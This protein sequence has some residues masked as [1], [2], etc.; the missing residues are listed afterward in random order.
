LIGL[1]RTIVVLTADH[2]VAPLPEDQQ[3]RRL[4]GGRIP[5]SAIFDPIEAALDAKYGEA[6]WI[7]ATAGSSP[8]LNHAVA[9][10]RGLDLEEVRNVAA[11]A[12][13][14][15]PQVA[16]VYTRD[17]LLRGQVPDDI[18]GRR[19]ARIYHLQ[20]SGDLEI[21]LQPYWRRS[22]SGTTHGTP[23]RYDSQVPL[24]FMGPGIRPGTYHNPVALN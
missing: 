21:V 10:E 12:V 4:P 7:L 15:V 6:K 19:I 14:T 24:V 1:D 18:I 20:R 5:G 8:Y 11:K 9:A 13:M 23:Y 16:R 2:G 22:S 3:A 17:Q